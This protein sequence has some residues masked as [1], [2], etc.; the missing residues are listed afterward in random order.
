MSP[1]RQKWKMLMK[2]G[3]EQLYAHR[4]DNLD[5]IDQFLE[6]H[7]LPKLTQEE[8]DNLNR[9]ISIKEIES[10]ISF[11]NR[12]HWTQIGFTGE[13]YQTFEEELTLP[14]QILPKN[15]RGGNTSE[16]ILQGQHYPDTKSRQGHYKK[17]K[18]KKITNQYP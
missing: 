16:F 2:E 3:Y 9:S 14:F 10:I 17:R 18:E 13:F 8:T 11:Q 4:F 15:G 5:E 12:E 1:L 6:R 7:N